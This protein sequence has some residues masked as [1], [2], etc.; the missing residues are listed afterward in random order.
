[1]LRGSNS[2]GEAGDF[3]TLPKLASG[4]GASLTH[5]LIGYCF[6]DA[7]GIGAKA[8]GTNKCSKHDVG[9]G[10]QL[11]TQRANRMRVIKKFPHLNEISPAQQWEKGVGIWHRQGVFDCSGEEKK[12]F[13]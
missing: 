11:W 12:K 7:A 13:P 3:G 10:G 9:T 6:L 2:T 5:P 4:T 8:S 1:M